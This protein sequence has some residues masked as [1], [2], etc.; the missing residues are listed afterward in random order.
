MTMNNKHW[1]ME[2]SKSGDCDVFRRVEVTPGTPGPDEIAI[3]VKAC[4]VNFADVL[5]RM[6]MYP[7]APKLPFVPGYEVAGIVRVVGSNVKELKVGDRAMSAAHFGGYTSFAIVEADKAL[8]IPDHMSFEEGAAALV[9]FMTAWVALHEMARIRAGD[10]V[11]VHGIA[12]GVGL[13]AL[14][15]A[16]NAK[17]KVFGTA[18][19]QEKLDYVKEQG[20]DYGIN[21]R[22]T[23]FVQDIRLNVDRR[24]MDVILDPLGGDNIAKDRKVMKPTG[25]VI[26]YGMANAVK[27]EKQNKLFAL[28]TGLKMF[29]IN[30]MGLFAQNHGIFGLNILRLWKYP[31][32][33]AVGESLLAEF[34]AK[35]LHVTISET[36]PLSKAGEAH[37][38][39]QNRKNIGKVVLNVDE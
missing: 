31:V 32:M 13:A 1:A 21:Y 23:D 14:Q 6:G 3:E 30:I 2:I 11:L 22:Q 27:G 34:E 7:E 8:P 10:N 39:L 18:G 24:P 15:I 4:G 36:F 20:L 25:K 5:M 26:V 35:R 33:R 19:S 17:C 29:H 16:K 12:G 28:V 37:R 38:Y 9:N